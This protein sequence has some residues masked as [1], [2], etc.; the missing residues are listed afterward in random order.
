MKGKNTIPVKMV[1]N[2][3]Y[4]FNVFGLGNH[5]Q[6]KWNLL[7]SAIIKTKIT[8]IMEDINSSTVIII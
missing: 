3:L 6:N 5:I 7:Q 4:C 2:N 8:E 1:F